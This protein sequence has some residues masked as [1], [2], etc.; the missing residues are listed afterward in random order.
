MQPP[1]GDSRKQVGRREEEAEWE[2]RDYTEQS[3]GMGRGRES[4]VTMEW[5]CMAERR[6]GRTEE[7]RRG[8][9]TDSQ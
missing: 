1:I 4:V 6:E 8:H 2:V 3:E 7:G 9:M 5:T